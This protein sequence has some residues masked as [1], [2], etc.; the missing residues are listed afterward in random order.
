MRAGGFAGAGAAALVAVAALAG[1][2][3]SP[4]GPVVS[5]TASVPPSL[6]P[7]ASATPTTPPPTQD[8]AAATPVRIRCGKLVPRAVATSLIADLRP[9]RGWTPPASSPSAP[10]GRLDG[11]TC[12]WTDGAADLLEVA[13]AR[14][15]ASD[16]LALKNDLVDRSNS[17]PTYGR[18]AYFQVADHVGRVDAFRGRMWIMARSNRFFEPGDAVQVMAAIDGALGFASADKDSPAPAPTPTASAT[19][20]A[21]PS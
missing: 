13:V 10:L 4:V 5:P 19:P 2:T 11:T 14:P 7:V 9:E 15:S 20:T 8:V 18:E 21:V 16:A 12:S 1:C 17:V 6:P 3:S